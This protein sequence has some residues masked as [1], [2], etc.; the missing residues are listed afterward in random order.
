MVDYDDLQKEL[1]HYRPIA[2]GQMQSVALLKR[3]EVKYVLPRRVLPSI[4]AAL[5]GDYAV[6]EVAGQR[7]NR[8]RTLYFDTDDFAMYRRHHAGAADR[9][10]VRARTYVD[11]A[12]SFLEVK[13]K[14]NK[15]RVVK[16]RMPTPALMTT[17]DAEAAAFVHRNCPYAVDAMQ[18]RLWNSYRRITL[19]DLVRQARITLDVN[20]RFDWQ[21][22]TA[23]LPHIVV[24]EVKQARASH[25]APFIRLMQAYHIRPTGFSKY[26]IGASLLYPDLK[27]NH[28]K[29]KHRLLAKLATADLS[30]APSNPRAGELLPWMSPNLALEG[31]HRELH[32]SL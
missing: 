26:C 18:P 22:R 12:S 28:F 21:A 7:L 13:H 2:L 11:S 8:Y 16:E 1:Q 3:V 4:L 32:R 17:L 19:V 24:A 23:A 27:Q 20:L 14:T 25:G 9:F 5:S 31:G 30:L 29:Q 6:L 15:K 10:K